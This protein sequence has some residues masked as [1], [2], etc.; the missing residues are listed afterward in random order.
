MPGWA[1]AWLLCLTI[2]CLFST[3]FRLYFCF[4]ALLLL[5]LSVRS[6][7]L[8][9]RVFVF[10]ASCLAVVISAFG[11]CCMSSCSFC[12]VLLFGCS[13]LWRSNFM[14]CF[15]FPGVSPSRSSLNPFAGCGNYLVFAC[16]L[17]AS[18]QLSCVFEI[19]CLVLS[20]EC[21]NGFWGLSLGIV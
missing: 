4:L 14:H 5:C 18:L 13:A 19:F 9:C 21:G 12:V 11:L 10:F 17:G 1:G 15:T 8:A 20:R 3:P 16:R 2:R 7:L 6:C